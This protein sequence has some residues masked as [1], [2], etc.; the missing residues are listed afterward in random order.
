M[1]K[2]I[3]L[4]FIANTAIASEILT[5]S[6]VDYLLKGIG[7][8]MLISAV[9]NNPKIAYDNLHEYTVYN[10]EHMPNLQSE[11]ASFS[12][13]SNYSLITDQPNALVES[14]TVISDVDTNSYQTVTSSLSNNTT[15]NQTF[16]T[17]SYTYTATQTMQT[18]TTNGWSASATQALNATVAGIGTTTTISGSV[19]GST[20][21]ATTT[22]TT[23]TYT[24]PSTSIV[25]P[26]GC[27][28]VANQTT[29]LTKVSGQYYFSNLVKDA[30]VSFSTNTNNSDIRSGK[31]D[32]AS[33][34]KYSTIPQ[35]WLKTEAD[36]TLRIYGTGNFTGNDSSMYFIEVHYEEIDPT[37][38]RCEPIQL[39]TFKSSLNKNQV[40]SI[41][42]DK[43]GKT[44]YIIEGTSTLQSSSQP[45]I[46]IESNKK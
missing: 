18:T 26:P 36:G 22:T 16:S 23:K 37:N 44:R 21:T 39:A 19:N 46:T 10:S 17:Q 29:Y 33:L 31:V 5:S 11:I 42:K 4:L 41:S 20:A 34:V 3:V 13:N 2:L 1:K 12:L 43:K 28:A 32:L 35:S 27:R 24:M 9:N 45:I 6:Q 40:V 14:S 7:S 15:Q 30:V 8:D 25:I 38:P